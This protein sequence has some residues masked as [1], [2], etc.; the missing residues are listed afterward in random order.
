MARR[1]ILIAIALLV[2]LGAIFLAQQWLR[3]AGTRPVAHVAHDAPV[4]AP[5]TEVLVAKT[6]LFE[7][8]F[9]RPET[10]TWQAW[11]TGPLPV[12]YLVQGK[13]RPTDLV[14]AVV[15]S[16]I[17]PGQPITFDQVVRPGERGFMAAVLTP[18][19]RA[20]TVNVNAST[21][22]AGF[23]FPGDRVDLIL[24]M[25]VTPVSGGSGRHVSETILHDV[26]VVGMD[27]SFTDGRKDEK[28]DLPVPR[29]A[30]LEVTPKQAESVTVAADLGVLS[31]SLRSLGGN[32]ASPDANRVTKTWDTD[33]TQIAL[34]KP[35]AAAPTQERVTA[36]AGRSFMVEV[37]R[38]SGDTQVALPQGAPQAAP[39]AAPQE[40]TKGG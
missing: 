22:Q 11:P 8:Q 1:I 27:Q 3:G 36:P 26:R 12:S 10:L 5:P 28:A 6:Q 2:S 37:V 17:T 15:R 33:V 30:T 16:R 32:D 20:V 25:T 18:G 29:T 7:G 21:G 40:A 35:G 24:T 19:N 38:G 13:V 34:A 39:Q 4:S 14:G 23:I 31:L 9:V